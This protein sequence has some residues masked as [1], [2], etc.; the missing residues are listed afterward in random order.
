[1]AISY[2]GRI[3]TH[4]TTGSP[5]KNWQVWSLG[6]PVDAPRSTVLRRPDTAKRRWQTRGFGQQITGQLVG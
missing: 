6:I 1:M 4:P 5:R 2:Q 3:A